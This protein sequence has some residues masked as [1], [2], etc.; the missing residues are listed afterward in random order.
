MRPSD[1][2]VSLN[3]LLTNLF[4]KHERGYPSAYVSSGPRYIT[5]SMEAVVSCITG[6]HR[7]RCH[8][9]HAGAQ[10][11]AALESL[12]RRGTQHLP[13]CAKDE[14]QPGAYRPTKETTPNV[15]GADLA[16]LNEIFDP[17]LDAAC[18]R[19]HFEALRHGSDQSA[20][21]FI[22]ELGRVAKLCEFGVASDILAYDE[23]V[24][25]IASPHLQRTF[26]KMGK[27]LTQQKALLQLLGLN[28]DAVSSRPIQDGGSARRA[29]QD[30]RPNGSHPPQASVQDGAG[31]NS[32]FVHLLDLRCCGHLLSSFPAGSYGC[33][34]PLET[35]AALGQLHCLPCQESDVFVVRT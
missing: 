15:Y 12:R 14:Q 1:V 33:L 34:L 7:Y 3:C 5:Y 13:A 17:H 16:L 2:R 29:M 25:G 11:G 19:A 8:R 27:D 18:L 4:G 23:I 24:S 35:D 26:F 28:V 22:Q 31:R 32:F 9:H 10:E 20:V 21:E 6:L 30:A